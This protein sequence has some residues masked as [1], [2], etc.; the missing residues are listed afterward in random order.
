MSAKTV[1][2]IGGKSPVQI[3]DFFVQGHLR[4]EGVGPRPGRVPHARSERRAG[5]CRHDL[6]HGLGGRRQGEQRD[7]GCG[8]AQDPQDG[9][10]LGVGRHGVTPCTRSKGGN[11]RSDRGRGLAGARDELGVAG[12]DVHA[13]ADDGFNICQEKRDL[14]VR[15]DADQRI[16][17]ARNDPLPQED[18]DPALLGEEFV[19][20]AEHPAVGGEEVHLPPQR[21]GDLHVAAMAPEGRVVAVALGGL[22]VQDDEVADALVFEV[23]LAIEFVDSGRIETGVRQQANHPDHS[24]LDQVQAGGLQRLQEAAGQADGDAILVQIFRRL[25]VVKRMRKGSARWAPSRLSSRTRSASS[26]SIC[27]LE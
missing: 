10:R 18:L 2:V 6:G 13:L 23:A 7:G 9:G 22:V 12:H 26:S 11:R 24:R 21:R 25:P 16:V 19:V 5:L 3:S 20:L 8:P 17:A 27:R 14:L 1:L 15:L 4:D